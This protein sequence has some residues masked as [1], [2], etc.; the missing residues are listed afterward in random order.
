MA[1]PL[2][3]GERLAD[4]LTLGEKRSGDLYTQ[5]DV[6]LLSTLAHSAALALENARLHEERMAILRQQLALVTAAQ[7]KERGRIARE[8]HD[9]VGPT[10]ASLNL[11]LRTARKLLEREHHPAAGGDRRAG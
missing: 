5:E 6:E 9:G 1:V 2:L 4:V 8:L 10:L 7:E 3:T 11:R